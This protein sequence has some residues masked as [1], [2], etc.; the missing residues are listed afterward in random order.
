MNCDGSS[1]CILKDTLDTR[2][3]ISWT[4]AIYGLVFAELFRLR[5]FFQGKVLRLTEFAIKDLIEKFSPG[6]VSGRTQPGELSSNG[7]EAC[8]VHEAEA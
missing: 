7:T 2:A 3:A 8:A 5:Y 4:I 1:W 6:T